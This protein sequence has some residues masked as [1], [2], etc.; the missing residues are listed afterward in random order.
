[1]ENCNN[2]LGE[3]IDG[4]NFLNLNKDQ[5]ESLSLSTD[6]QQTLLNIINDMVHNG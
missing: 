4:Q 5:L 3:G 2:I 6:A 1:M